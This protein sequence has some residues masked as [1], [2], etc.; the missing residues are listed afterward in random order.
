MNTSILSNPSPNNGYN[1]ILGAFAAQ[2]APPEGTLGGTNPSVHNN[3]KQTFVN[4]VA[5]Y[6]FICRKWSER[7][8]THF[9]ER[10]SD[11]Y[12]YWQYTRP[13]R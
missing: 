11:I 7:Y 1:A 10:R 12:F 4:P 9:H 13:V 5:T 6:P 8:E 2:P 3:V